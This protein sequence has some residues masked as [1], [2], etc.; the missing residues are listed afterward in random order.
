MF[1]RVRRKRDLTW[2]G[3]AIVEMVEGGVSITS[4]EPLKVLCGVEVSKIGWHVF[5]HHYGK[6]YVCSYSGH[7]EAEGRWHY[8]AHSDD[9][10][11]APVLLIDPANQ[12]IDCRGACKRLW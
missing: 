11:D 1:Y 3:S 5:K 2:F 8:D 10:T 9:D 12:I 6:G 7:S 4:R